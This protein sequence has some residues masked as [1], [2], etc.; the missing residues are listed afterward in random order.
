[1]F[2]SRQQLQ[3][4]VEQHPGV[5]LRRFEA[6]PSGPGYATSWSCVYRISSFEHGGWE[7]VT[8]E[9]AGTKTGSEENT[10]KVALLRLKHWF[11]EL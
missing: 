6:M 8:G 4:F 3:M 2:N 11:S 7:D 9:P 1:M 5:Q 10:A